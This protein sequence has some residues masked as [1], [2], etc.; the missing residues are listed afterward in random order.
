MKADGYGH[1]AVGA[2]RA[3]LAGGATSL[4][5]AL[6]EEGAALRSAGIEV[7]ILVLSEPPDDVMHEAFGSGLTPTLYTPAG[8]DA[9]HHAVERSGGG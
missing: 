2:A 7:P 8:I 1:G 6:V 4:A 9:A 5:V 3:S